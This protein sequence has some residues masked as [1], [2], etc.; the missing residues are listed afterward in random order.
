MF[1]RPPAATPILP[2]VTPVR[3][4]PGLDGSVTG[5]VYIAMMMFMGAAAVNS[6]ANLLFGVLGLMIGIGIVTWLINWLVLRKLTVTRALPEHATVGLRCVYTYEVR[7]NKRFWPSFSVTIAE[8]DGADAFTRQP[9]GYLLHAAARMTALVP[10]EVVPRRRGLHPLERYQVATSFPFGFIKRAETRKQRDALLVYPALAEVHPR[11]L[12]LARSAE[13]SGAQMRPRRGGNDEFYGVKEHRA[14]DSPRWIYWRRSART[15]TLVA[16]EMTHVSPPRLMILLD[17]FTPDDSPASVDA[18]E[19]AIA[20]AG[21]LASLALE[22][23]LQVGLAVWSDDDL[24]QIAPNHGKRHRRDVLAVL[25]RLPCLN[26]AHD[27]QALMDRSTAHRKGGTTAFLVTARDVKMSLGE[28]A[29][30]GTIVISPSS[31][32]TQA[33]FKFD[34][35]IEFSQCAPPAPVKPKGAKSSVVSPA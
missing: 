32:Q 1:D 34:P 8:L 11:V 13:K 21:S 9:Q 33:W 14:G 30:G 29:R 4:R 6:Q 22:T 25:A 20:I 31:E 24:V 17:S 19:R 27:V 7:N 16:K 28:H 26:R 23:G 15:G 5:V 2:G 18:A 10:C 35:S 3:R 12:A